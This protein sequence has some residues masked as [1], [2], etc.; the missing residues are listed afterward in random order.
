MEHNRVNKTKHIYLGYDSYVLKIKTQAHRH[1]GNM[2]H[3][4]VNK[5][6]CIYLG[7]DSYVLKIKIKAHS[8]SRNI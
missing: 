8:H 2:E 1:S 4:S 3:N 6:M 5:T 7:Y